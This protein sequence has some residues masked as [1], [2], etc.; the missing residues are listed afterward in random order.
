MHNEISGHF[1]S[2]HIYIALCFSSK[3]H[4]YNLNSVFFYLVTKVWPFQVVETIYYVNQANLLQILNGNYFT[5]MFC[6]PVIFIAIS[7]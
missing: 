6:T 5:Y 2:A 4:I 7:I 3:I 1:M